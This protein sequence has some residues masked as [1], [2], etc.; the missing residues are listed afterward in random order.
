MVLVVPNVVVIVDGT[1][2]VPPSARGG[3][4]ATSTV[5]DP[6][7]RSTADQMRDPAHQL[8]QPLA[9]ALRRRPGRTRAGG[10]WRGSR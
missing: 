6:S 4:P 10:G 9:F 3:G 2:T 8:I 7:S 5:T 1:L